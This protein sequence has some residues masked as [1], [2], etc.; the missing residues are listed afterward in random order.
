MSVDSQIVG[1]LPQVVTMVHKDVIVGCLG[2]GVTGYLTYRTI[3]HLLIRQH[4]HRLR[5]ENHAALTRQTEQ[6]RGLLNECGYSKEE[7]SAISSLP[8]AELTSQLQSGEITAS[9][10]LLAFQAASMEVTSRTNCIVTWLED[11]Q[12]TALHL[13]SLAP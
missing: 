5:N 7:L 8:W 12:E 3:K 13:D 10:A 1:Y 2:A 6:I 9:K 11:A 4:V